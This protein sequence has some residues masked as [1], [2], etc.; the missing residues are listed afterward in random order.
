MAP[1]A[2]ST[3]SCSTPRLPS[4]EVPTT[5]TFS[6]SSARS[7]FA[8][9]THAPRRAA[10]RRRA[11][12]SAAVACASC[13]HGSLTSSAR[14]IRATRRAAASSGGSG[15]AR[16]G[17][18]RCTLRCW[19]RPHCTATGACGPVATL[20]AA[21]PPAASKS[22]SKRMPSTVTLALGRPRCQACSS[23]SCSRGGYGWRRPLR[24][25][26]QPAVSA[27][28][29]VGTGGLD[30][31]AGA[32]VG[33][34]EGEGVGER[35]AVGVGVGVGE[36]AG[37][38][39]GGGDSVR[40]LKKLSMRRRFESSGSS[41]PHSSH[42][43]RVASF[44]TSVQARQ[45]RQANASLPVGRSAGARLAVSGVASSVVRSMVSICGRRSTGGR[46]SDG[47]RVR[48][49]V[50]EGRAHKELAV[51]LGVEQKTIRWQ[52]QL[53]TTSIE[54]HAVRL[55][56]RPHKTNWRGTTM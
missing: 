37:D 10:T 4:S 17:G 43:V 11:S 50:W 35:E 30:V 2:P 8:S 14:V 40:S 18:T 47:A 39:C 12:S 16:L 41:Q 15:R 20:P 55:S 25:T 26:C 53:K 34:G 33:A 9:S 5:A 36:A 7:R 22:T 27:R 28:A 52:L 38:S 32:G 3:A 46:A 24:C 31:G 6:P 56:P 13:S 54:N 1:P 23:T 49:E 21:T 29:G 42:W 48:R 19:A 51:L 45:A 44:V